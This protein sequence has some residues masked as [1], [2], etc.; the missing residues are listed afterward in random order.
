MCLTK[1]EKHYIFHNYFTKVTE[2]GVNTNKG[3]R[4]I[5]K[6]FLTTKGFLSGNE[7]TLI[8]NDEVIAEEKILAEIILDHCTN[9]VKRSCGV[10]PTKLNLVNSS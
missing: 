4:K 3:F 9:I 10:I 6:P 5:I 7:V 1:K 2:G 8:E